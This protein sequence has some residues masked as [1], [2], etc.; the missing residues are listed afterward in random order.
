MK[1]K[2]KKEKIVELTN[3]EMSNIHGGL[4]DAD[5]GNSKPSSAHDFTCCWCIKIG[6]SGSTRVPGTEPTVINP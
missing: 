2:L 5:G 6:G 3:A 1:L 4:V